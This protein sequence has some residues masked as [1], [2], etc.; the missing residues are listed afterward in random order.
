MFARG[1]E[2][3]YLALKNIQ[4]IV[5]KISYFFN[6]KITTCLLFALFESDGPDGVK[7]KIHC[8]LRKQAVSTTPSTPFI[9]RES[10]RVR[11][12]LFKP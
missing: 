5:D 4:I 12:S 3:K 6:L 11:D 7:Q 10:L 1:P 9:S 2:E 8:I